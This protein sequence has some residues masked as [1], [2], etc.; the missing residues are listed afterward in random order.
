[1]TELWKHQADAL[2]KMHN[3]CILL[4]GV[5]SGKSRTA[6]AYWLEKTSCE[7]LVIITT[8]MKRDSLEWEGDLAAFGKS[9]HFDD[10]SIDS[11]NKI[12]DFVDVEGALF[13]FDE[14]RL[15]GSGAWTKAFLKIAKKNQWILL[16]GTPGDT[17]MDYIPVFVANGFYKNRTAFTQE[18]VIYDRFA[19]Y[20][21]VQRYVGE[22]KLVRL[23]RRILVEM[24]TTRHTVRHVKRHLLGYD[25]ELYDKGTKERFDYF[26]DEPMINASS[27]C[28]FQRRVVNSSDDRRE[29]LV[30]L[31]RDSVPRAIIF[32]S[33][34]Y[35][36]EILRGVCAELGRTWFERNGHKHDILD[37]SLEE[38]V[39]LVQYSSGSEAWNCVST[40]TIILFSQVYS[41]RVREQV[42]G[43][44][45]RMN[46][47]FKDLYYHEF[48]SNSTID[49]AISRAIQT[50]KRFNES[51]YAGF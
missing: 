18:H 10:I 37:E 47:P 23:R 6:I 7:K 1:M 11:W 51:A 34:D 24:P 22:G 35:E 46:T 26:K 13:I 17:W 38:W 50:K 40:D 20:P 43:R 2:E 16:S 5:G 8:A 45:D 31:L 28:Y 27:L 25:K 19:K 30:E 12:G 42:M 9:T 41:W 29:K 21:K 3:G 36:L 33:F 49:F 39:Y 44:I 14:Q 48:S 32:Y 15:V 4:G